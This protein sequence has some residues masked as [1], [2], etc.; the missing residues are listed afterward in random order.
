M[1]ITRHTRAMPH[2][3]VPPPKRLPPKPLAIDSETM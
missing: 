3:A 2:N 1:D